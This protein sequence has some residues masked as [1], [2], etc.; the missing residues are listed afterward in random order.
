MNRY[1]HLIRD[2]EFYSAKVTK[3][4]K[5]IAKLDNNDKNA[6]IVAL[7]IPIIDFLNELSIGIN[8][9][10]RSDEGCK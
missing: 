1:V 5:E 7:V 4:L 3:V 2:E 8:N 10:K 9:R 6:L